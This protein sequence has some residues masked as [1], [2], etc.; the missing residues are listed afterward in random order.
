MKNQGQEGDRFFPW[1]EAYSYSYS[2]SPPL[3]LLHLKPELFHKPIK[4]FIYIYTHTHRE[5][6]DLGY[7]GLEVGD[8]FIHGVG[9]TSEGVRGP[10]NGVGKDSESKAEVPSRVS[11][12]PWIP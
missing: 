7:V 1:V 10:V 2:S 12:Y 8:E 5:R 6:E 9:V 11:Y 3:L 4:T